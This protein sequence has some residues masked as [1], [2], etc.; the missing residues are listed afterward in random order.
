MKVRLLVALYASL[1]ALSCNVSAT[2][3]VSIVDHGTYVSDTVTG[4]DWLDITETAGWSYNQVVGEMG[5]GGAFEGWSYATRAQVST[6]FDAFGGDSDYYSNTWSTQN[7][8]LLEA[9]GPL[10]GDL[11]CEIRGCTPGDGLSHFITADIATAADEGGKPPG[12]IEA[13]EHW[14]AVVYDYVTPHDTSF[15]E[16]VSISQLTEADDYSDLEFGSALIRTSFVTSPVPVPASVW[17][18]GSGLLG[19][20]GIAKRKIAA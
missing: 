2:T 5:S 15:E 14:S 8:G 20:V 1:M 16:Y 18:F 11:G 7:N 10:M 19:L 3:I 17:L 9:I 6:L 13:G 12:T 4:L